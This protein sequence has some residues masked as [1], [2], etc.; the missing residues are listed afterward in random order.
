MTTAQRES[1]RIYCAPTRFV[2]KPISG[3]VTDIQAGD[4]IAP[5]WSTDIGNYEHGLLNWKPTQPARVVEVSGH[6]CKVSINGKVYETVTYNRVRI[7][8]TPRTSKLVLAVLPKSVTKAPAPPLPKPITSIA[9]E[10]TPA[11]YTLSRSAFGSRFMAA[12][13]AGQINADAAHWHKP[14]RVTVDQVIT[15][16]DGYGWKCSDT[17]KDYMLDDRLTYKWVM[18]LGNG[19]AGRVAFCNLRPV[20]ES[21]RRYYDAIQGD[22]MFGL[23]EADT[24]TPAMLALPAWA[25]SLAG[26]A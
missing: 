16:L 25:I 8:R 5:A 22:F 13:I 9:C 1:T 4:W 7:A 6:H 18:P 23:C 2:G 14:E 24:L 20:L 26:V 3:L 11:V 17:G 15:W 10:S 21:R 19:R 12:D